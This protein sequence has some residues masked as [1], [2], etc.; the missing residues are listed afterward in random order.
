MVCTFI[1]VH[2]YLWLCIW[3]EG[4]FPIVHYLTDEENSVQ[5]LSRSEHLLPS[6]GP[7]CGLSIQKTQKPSFLL[8]YVLKIQLVCEGVVWRW[9]E[10]KGH[11]IKC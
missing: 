10:Q 5:E 6:Q 2:M 1:T 3:G 4:V 11:W 8:I 7:V 9:T